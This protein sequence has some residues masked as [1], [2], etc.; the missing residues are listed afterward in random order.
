MQSFWCFSEQ[1]STILKD[2]LAWKNMLRH[3]PYFNQLHFLIHCDNSTVVWRLWTLKTRIF[4]K[5]IPCKS[6]YHFEKFRTSKALLTSEEENMVF[7]A[8]RE[9]L[10]S[11]SYCCPC[12]VTMRTSSLRSKL[13]F[14]DD[15]IIACLSNNFVNCSQFMQ[16]SVFIVFIV[17]FFFKCQSVTVS[18]IVLIKT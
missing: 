13:H 9:V 8:G 12:V 1:V 6:S 17:H 10:A 5:T 11:V 7:P 3:L 2:K 15:L 14:T 18:I 16:F 4:K